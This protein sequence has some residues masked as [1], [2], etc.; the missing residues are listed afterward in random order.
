MDEAAAGQVVPALGE[1]EQ[2]GDGRGQQGEE[3]AQGL[4]GGQARVGRVAQQ[5]QRLGTN[6]GV[7]QPQGS[8][9]RVIDAFL[10]DGYVLWVYDY[11]L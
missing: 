4:Q 1:G 3:E 11:V 10:L 5:H 2:G 8:R 7:M 9:I 6:G